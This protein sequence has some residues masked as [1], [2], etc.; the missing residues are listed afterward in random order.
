MRA[1]S[2]TLTIP[3]PPDYDQH[4]SDKMRQDCYRL[5]LK[6]PR[7]AKPHLE[8]RL[9]A[10]SPAA[11]PPQTLPSMVQT[12][13]SMVQTLPVLPRHC[14]SEYNPSHPTKAPSILVN[15]I[16][17]IINYISSEIHGPKATKAPLL[18][19]HNPLLATHGSICSVQTPPA[20]LCP[21]PPV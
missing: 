7:L 13:P 6:Q 18:K 19:G 8:S 4:P 15:H 17:F 2:I 16:K 14:E 10:Y 3:A 1:V 11:R 5:S 9:E 12:L 21:E 20:M